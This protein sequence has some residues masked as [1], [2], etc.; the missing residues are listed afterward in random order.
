MISRDFRVIY[1]VIRIKYVF[2]MAFDGDFMGYEWDRV[3]LDV[4][5]VTGYYILGFGHFTVC[6]LEAIAHLFG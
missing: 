3:Y 6:E 5:G 1:I 2:V 4:N